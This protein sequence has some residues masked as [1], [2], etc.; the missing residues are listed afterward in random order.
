MFLSAG[1]IFDANL[2]MGYDTAG[3][4]ALAQD[5]IH[6]AHLL[7][8]FY[9]DNSIDAT[10]PP[11]P[12]HA[13]VRQTGLYLQGFMALSG[14]VIATLSGGLYAN[15]D[16]ELVNTDASPHVHLDT[17]L[18]NLAGNG[19]VFHLGGK[20]YASAD[21]SL[22]IPNPIGPNITLFHYNLAYDELLNFDPPPPPDFNL[23][24]TV[25]DVTDQHTLLLDVNKMGAGSR[26]TVQPFHDLPVPNGF[27]ADGIRV[28]YPN[29]IVL[30]VERKNDA[31]TNY[32][33]LIGLNGRGA[34]RRVDQ[35][36]RPVPRVRR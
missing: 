2:T 22:T 29:E 14:S 13:P 23:P 27:V 35:R 9:F 25:I 5:P 19:K 30:F 31:T 36:D 33:N 26:V 34:R 32:Y 24:V 10:A 28:D 3:L 8:G 1:I 17:M 18:T 21:I 15:V 6:P 4:I 20:V 7:H 16:V 12:N 11:I